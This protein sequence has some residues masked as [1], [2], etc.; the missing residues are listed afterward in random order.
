MKKE[1]KSIINDTKKI[2]KE[3]LKDKKS[4]IITSLLFGLFVVLAA[5]VIFG[6]TMNIDTA[7]F[8]FLIGFKSKFLTGFMY[9][10]TE[11]GSTK[12]VVLLVLVGIVI[13]YF[14]KKLDWFK[15]AFLNVGC[16][17][18]M[19]KVIKSIVRRPRPEWRWI[20][21][22]GFSF[23]SGHTIC[24]VALYGCLMLFVA[25]SDL[26]Y[27]KLIIVLLGF[28]GAIIGISRIYFGVHYV[29]DVLGSLLLASGLLVLTNSF[30]NVEFKK[31]AKNK[32]K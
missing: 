20:K 13:S 18:V 1:I 4:L 11:L 3:V 14:I 27:K 22:D 24:A 30:M 15:Y 12:L 19:M 31:N 32:N 10:F 16:C 21:E 25:K 6:A 29:S 8:D 23:P 9:F 17:A 26:K 7:V 5:L 28:I 2:T